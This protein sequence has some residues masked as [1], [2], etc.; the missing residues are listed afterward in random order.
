VRHETQ[1]HHKYCM[2]GLFHMERRVCR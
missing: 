1:A 2:G